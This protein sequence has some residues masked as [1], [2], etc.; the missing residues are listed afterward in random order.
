MKGKDEEKREREERGDE[1]TIEEQS[2]YK[3]QLVENYFVV[4]GSF[5]S[6]VC[7][8][9]LKRYRAS[10]VKKMEEEASLSLSVSLSPSPSPSPSPSRS[11]EGGGEGDDVSGGGGEE[12]EEKGTLSGFSLS[13]FLSLSPF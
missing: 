4:S 6:C 12:E 7:N 3:S 1:L 9:L 8:E 5:L 2:R 10:L 13:F 11:S